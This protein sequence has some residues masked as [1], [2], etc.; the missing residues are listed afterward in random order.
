MWFED[1][2]ATI[3]A[4]K[5]HFYGVSVQYS[6]FQFFFAFIRTSEAVQGPLVYNE[7]K[8]FGSRADNLEI[9]PISGIWHLHCYILDYKK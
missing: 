3:G 2:L 9:G 4:F 1:I 8:N 6:V 5:V 7:R